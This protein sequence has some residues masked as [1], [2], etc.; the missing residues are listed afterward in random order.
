V[1]RPHADAATD[2]EARADLERRIRAKARRFDLRVLVRLLLANGYAPESILFQGNPEGGATG[3]VHDVE[4]R[5]RPHRVV[6]VTV[7]LGLLGDNSL[8]PSYFLQ[9]VEKSRDPDRFFDFIRFFDH[10]LVNNYLYAVY[11]EDDPFAYPDYGEVQRAFVS[12]GG[13]A[14]IATLAWLGQAYFPE[15]GVNVRR[16]AFERST[17]AHA[18]RTGE[19]ALDGTSVIGRY[20]RS[21]AQGFVLELVAEEETNS[22]GRSWAALVRKRLRDRLMPVLAPFRIPLMVR[23]RVLQHA[24]WAK[25]DFPSQEESG[26]LGYDRIRGDPDSGHTVVLFAGTTGAEPED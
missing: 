14:S 24:S 4:F 21:D 15:F 1:T 20:Y 11:P 10:R 7:N 18:F 13:F 19:G 16:G 12:M 6:L 25:L 23:L 17:E 8:L 22:R 2:P 26:Y 5:T 3:I 9:E